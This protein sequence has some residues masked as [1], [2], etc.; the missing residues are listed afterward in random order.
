MH[1]K[2]V[3][4]HGTTSWSG[5]L[6]PKYSGLAWPSLNDQ[7]L[8]IVNGPLFDGCY[9]VRPS[10]RQWGAAEMNRRSQTLARLEV[11]SRRD[12]L[13]AFTSPCANLIVFLT[14]IFTRIQTLT[15][16]KLRFRTKF[17]GHQE[18]KKKSSGQKRCCP[19]SS[20]YDVCAYIFNYTNLSSIKIWRV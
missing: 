19:K 1:H 5:Q 8:V 13:L 7:I 9:H 16:S 14:S 20:A 4:V 2:E 3:E 18:G 15:C 11:L 6:L 10:C 17:R 12:P